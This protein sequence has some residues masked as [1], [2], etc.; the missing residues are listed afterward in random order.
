[1]VIELGI[2]N[3]GISMLTAFG[4]KKLINGKSTEI[5]TRSNKCKESQY[6]A[7]VHSVDLETADLTARFCKF[8]FSFINEWF[9]NGKSSFC[10]FL[11]GLEK[12]SYCG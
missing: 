11:L 10:S 6:V 8:V 5:Q 4:G 3:M 1:M 12:V 2:S 9:H 7:I